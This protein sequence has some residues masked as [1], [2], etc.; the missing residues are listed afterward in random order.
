MDSEYSYTLTMMGSA[1]CV[2]ATEPDERDPVRRLHQAVLDV[3]GQLV[4]PA[5]KPR[6]GFLDWEGRA[7]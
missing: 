2:T 1:H 6:I 5:P 7:Q 3:T 4:E